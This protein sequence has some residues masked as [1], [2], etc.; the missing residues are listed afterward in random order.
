MAQITS[1][2][3]D[4]DR[5]SSSGDIKEGKTTKMIEHQTAKIPSVTFLSFAIG[6]IIL[7][8]GLAIFS[9]RKSY[10]NFVGLWVPTFLLLGI[11]NKL[12]KLEGGSDQFEKKNAA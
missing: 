5:N 6:S 2:L 12:V 11:Y 8:G 4:L 10:A 7:S 3:E 1:A 9:E